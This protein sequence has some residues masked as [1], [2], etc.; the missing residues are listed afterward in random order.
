MESEKT[1]EQSLNELEIIVK[2]L[3]QG[4]VDLEKSIEKYTTAMNLAK[5]CGNKLNDATAK[6]NKITAQ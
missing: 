3:E 6:V 4:N 5:E 2:E 1:F